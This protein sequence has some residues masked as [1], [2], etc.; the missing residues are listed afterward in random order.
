M[1]LLRN[2]EFK[3]TNLLPAERI[4]QNKNVLVTIRG[5]AQI[6]TGEMNCMGSY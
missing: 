4:P 1:Q 2:W 6:K 3:S 5:S